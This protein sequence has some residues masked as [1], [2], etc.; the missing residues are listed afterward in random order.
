MST[1]QTTAQRALGGLLGLLLFLQSA[2]ALPA[3]CGL[4]KAAG[5]APAAAAREG[6][7]CAE[8][9]VPAA[10]ASCCPMAEGADVGQAPTPTDS[11]GP[12]IKRGGCGCRIAPLPNPEPALPIVFGGGA[13]DILRHIDA[14]TL[15]SSRTIAAPHL[16]GDDAPL[17]WANPPPGSGT[18][19]WSA[20]GSALTARPLAAWA[21]AAGGP[22]TQRVLCKALL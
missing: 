12:D 9:R 4:L 10:R 3:P 15:V 17:A 22:W 11:D 7:C 2:V 8:R 14:R 21:L 13:L 20:R 5:L 19:P 1:S 6:C 16:Q 18:S